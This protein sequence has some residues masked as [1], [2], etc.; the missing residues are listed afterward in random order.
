MASTSIDD[1]P[2]WTPGPAEMKMVALGADVNISPSAFPGSLLGTKNPKGYVN[3]FIIHAT[4]DK[5]PS[6]ISVC[7]VDALS[8]LYVCETSLECMPAAQHAALV[9][10]VK[11]IETKLG[12]PQKKSLL[13][14]C[15]EKIEAA[16]AKAV[17]E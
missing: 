15:L 10:Y 3:E 5:P 1:L 9:A 13:A 11:E 6:G 14:R 17:N 12:E 4:M 8:A 2:A 7:V 16:G